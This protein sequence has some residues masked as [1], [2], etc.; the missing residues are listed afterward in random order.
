MRHLEIRALFLIWFARQQLLA[1]D[2]YWALRG[3]VCP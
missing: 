2:K 3:A 1:W